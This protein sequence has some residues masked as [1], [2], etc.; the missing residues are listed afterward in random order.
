MAAA[1]AAAA[2]AVLVLVLVVVA[3]VVVAVVAAME[4]RMEMEVGT[5]ALEDSSAL[6]LRSVRATGTTHGCDR[7]RRRG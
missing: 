5:V 2:A 4:A 1:A 3:A 6:L 7:S